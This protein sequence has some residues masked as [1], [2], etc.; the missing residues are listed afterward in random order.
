MHQQR[1]LNHQQQKAERNVQWFQVY[2]DKSANIN[3]SNQKCHEV[4]YQRCE[5]CAHN[6]VFGDEY[7]VQNN[8]HHSADEYSERNGG[9]F[10]ADHVERAEEGDD[11]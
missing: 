2:A 6:A 10:L 8:I 5:S 3:G 11:R 9:V 7:E 1:S 4:A